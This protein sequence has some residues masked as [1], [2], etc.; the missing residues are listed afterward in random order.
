MRQ[1]NALK[2]YAALAGMW[3]F[4]AV[5]LWFCPAWV[6][7]IGL[8]FA[9]DAPCPTHPCELPI[10]VIVLGWLPLLVVAGAW[11]TYVIATRRRRRRL[12]DPSH[13][14]PDNPG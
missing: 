3:L 6:I 10:Q 14:I 2:R 7:G 13:Q 9:F 4:T 8:G 1:P 12:G 5:V 11:A